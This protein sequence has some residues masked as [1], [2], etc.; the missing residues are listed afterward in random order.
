MTVVPIRDFASLE[1]YAAV[2][3]PGTKN[4]GQSLR[5]LRETGLD[6]EVARAAERGTAVVGV[7]GGMQLLGH[8]IHDPHGLEG[9]E[10]EGL[11]LLDITTTLMPEKATRQREAAWAGRGLVRGYEI[12]HGRSTPGPAVREYLA[13]GLGW[14]QGSVRGVYLHGLFENTAYRQSFLAALGWHGRAED[15]HARLDAEIERVASLVPASGW[16]VD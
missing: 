11:R 9:A 1:G 8:R 3:L 15:W 5:S 2:I 12:H 14:E 13:D 7:C 4:T 16:F 10:A 6:A